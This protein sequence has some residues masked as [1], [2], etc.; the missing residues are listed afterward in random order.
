[1]TSTS[2]LLGLLAVFVLSWTAAALWAARTVAVL[3]DRAQW[4]LFA[5]G[6]LATLFLVSARA[7]IPA[8][9]VRLWDESFAIGWAM[10][11]VSA[12]GYAWCWW[13]R[14]YLGKLWSAGVSRKEGH[15][16]V[17]TGPYGIVR[18]PIYSGAILAAFAFAVARATPLGIL[19][20]LVFTA[21][22]TWKARVEE[23]FLQE[24]LGP[25]YDEYR[26]RVPMLVPF[27]RLRAPLQ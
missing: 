21:F 3:P 27:L 4:P 11:A 1:M 12:F 24:E 25:A 19:M 13:A 18:H 26:R 9:Q 10:V 6:L 16:V 22:F 17:D 14:V 20:A 8:L 15:R 5:G 2:A 7:F 23:R